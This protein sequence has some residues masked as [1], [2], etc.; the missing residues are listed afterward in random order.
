MNNVPNLTQAFHKFFNE[1]AE[2]KKRIEEFMKEKAVQIK[3]T[4][5][6]NRQNTNGIDI[7][8]FKG[9][10]PTDTVKDIAFQ[11]KGEFPRQSAFI[12]ATTFE[13]KPNLTLMLSDDLVEQG[14]NAST[15]VR[16]AAKNI[17]GGGGGQPHFATA[18]GKNTD[19]LAKAVDE[20]V[21]KLK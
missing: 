12:G 9:H 17:Q 16:E 18:G 11:I 6:K 4:V 8:T 10:L 1:S 15:I 2:M 3:D 13:A 21:E 5:I 14:L 19:G 7:F 20:I